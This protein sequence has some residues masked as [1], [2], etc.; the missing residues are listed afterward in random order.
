MIE[1]LQNILLPYCEILNKLQC[2]KARLFKVL[3]AL[4]YFVQFWKIFSDSNLG[5][6]M[7]GRLEKRWN[8]WEQP[9]LLLSFLLHLKYHLA[10]FNSKLNNLSYTYLG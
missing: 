6:H 9:L 1:L 4:S 2:D 7:I 3:Y 10:Y 8:Q 5:D